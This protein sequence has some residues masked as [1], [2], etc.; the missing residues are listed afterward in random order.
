MN[1]DRDRQSKRP[2]RRVPSRPQRCDNLHEI[3]VGV[4]MASVLGGSLPLTHLDRLAHPSD[5]IVPTPSEATL[6]RPTVE[7]DRI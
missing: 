4:L 6:W 7:S 5:A 3:V 1:A 2:L